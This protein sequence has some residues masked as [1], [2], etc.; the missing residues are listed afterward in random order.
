MLSG[1]SLYSFIKKHLPFV[2]NNV[3]SCKKNNLS[4]LVITTRKQSFGQGNIFTS[5]CLFTGGS[6][7]GGG[8]LHPGGLATLPRALWYMVNKRVVRIEWNAFLLIICSGKKTFLWGEVYGFPLDQVL[9]HSRCFECHL[10]Y[11]T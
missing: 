9:Y 8:G 7:S 1:M 4:L 3:K 11:L 10:V 6:A 5:V 2:S